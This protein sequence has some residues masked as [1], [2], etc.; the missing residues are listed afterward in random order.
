M[1]LGAWP[2]QQKFKIYMK[3]IT[4]KKMYLRSPKWSAYISRY[5]LNWKRRMKLGNSFGNGKSL[6]HDISLLVFMIQELY[7]PGSSLRVSGLSQIPPMSS[8]FSKHVG[9]IPTSR[10]CL[11]LVS[12][13][14]PA[15]ITQHFLVICK[16][17]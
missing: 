4:F 3:Y 14:T 17:M 6:K 8:S 1:N 11:M 15:P 7:I 9:S 10:R 2:L 12:P 16:Y 5:L 13:D